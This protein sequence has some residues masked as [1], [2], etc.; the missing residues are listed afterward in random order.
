VAGEPLKFS[1][2]SIMTTITGSDRLAVLSSGNNYT[3]NVA[4]LFANVSTANLVIASSNSIPSNSASNGVQGQLV[5]D[6][7]N[8]YMCVANNSWIRFTGNTF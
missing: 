4:V 3:V 8:L 7:T 1:N 6:S 2:L 5:W